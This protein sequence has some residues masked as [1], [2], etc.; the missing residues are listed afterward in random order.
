VRPFRPSSRYAAIATG[1]TLVL[2]LIWLPPPPALAQACLAGAEPRMHFELYFGRNIGETLGVPEEA[3]AKFLDEEI[4]PRFPDGLS[5]TD[6]NGQWKDTASGRIVREP[7]KVL[8]IIAPS[9]GATRTKLAEIIELYKS[10]HSQQS[11][12]MTTKPV[13]AAF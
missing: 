2:S 9:D 6:I 13:C 5:V 7:G 1:F 12:L 3:W 4:T 11:V 10:R 8:G